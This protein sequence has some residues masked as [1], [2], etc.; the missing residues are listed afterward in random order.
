[1]VEHDLKPSFKQISDRIVQAEIQLDNRK[2][3]AISVYAPT[4]SQSEKQPET[5]EDFYQELESA[6]KKI[7]NRDICVVLGDFNAKTGSGWRDYPSVMGRFGKG[8]INNNGIALLELL[9]ANNMILTNTCFRHKLAHRTTWEAPERFTSNSKDE[10]GNYKPLLG[11]DNLPR[12]Q[13]FR[14]Q[15]DYIAVKQQHKRFVTNS[16]SY[17]NFKTD[18]DHK[19]VKMTI[20]LEWYK[21]KP[22]RK[23]KR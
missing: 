4:L 23:V 15:I 8:H 17:S 18:T 3:Y 9:Q 11:P 22:A 10:N 12:R 20:K 13:P 21:L 2:L 6:I 5:R 7:P 16:R 19:M 1:M 14:N